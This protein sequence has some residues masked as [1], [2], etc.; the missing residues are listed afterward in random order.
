MGDLKHLSVHQWIRSAVPDSQQPTSPI[1]FLFFETSATAL[2]GTTG[3]ELCCMSLHEPASLH[4]QMLERT[5]S[6]YLTWVDCPRLEN[7]LMTHII[8]HYTC[9]DWLWERCC[10]CNSIQ[11][12]VRKTLTLAP[13]AGDTAR[14]LRLRPIESHMQKG[15]SRKLNQDRGGLHG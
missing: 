8:H 14:T 9:F 1:G 2:C 15:L 3:I 6:H 4:A 11:R 7:A 12:T 13:A 5:L 10:S